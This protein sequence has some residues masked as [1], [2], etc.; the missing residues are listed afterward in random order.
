MQYTLDMLTIDFK[1]SAYS[2][3]KIFDFL[4]S[5][6]YDNRFYTCRYINLNFAFDI[7]SQLRGVCHG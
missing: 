1:V 7:K 6:G 2:I 4:M 3:Q 5:P